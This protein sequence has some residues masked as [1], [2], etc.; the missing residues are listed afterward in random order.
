MP[1]RIDYRPTLDSL[2]AMTRLD[3]SPDQDGDDLGS[4]LRRGDETALDAI[5]DDYGPA[6]E[7]YLR[8]RFGLHNHDADD[9]L[10]TAI[11]NLWNARESFDHARRPLGAYF[12]TI[13][14]NAAIDFLR[15]KGR[16]P[17]MV[18]LN[19]GMHAQSPPG[20]GSHEQQ[21]TDPRL[22]RL[23]QAISD[24]SDLDQQILLAGVDGG[25]WAQELSVETG[26]SANSLR[27]RRSRLLSR[28]SKQMGR[29]AAPSQDG[30]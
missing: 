5:R 24:L 18:S 6:T 12:R 15:K 8:T 22:L 11:V 13:L 23:R 17:V 2:S 7:A 20:N 26:R 25:S 19:N 4:R 10:S 1:I 21:I 3:T 27:V 16:E 29:N 30:P 28:L 14:K 9:V